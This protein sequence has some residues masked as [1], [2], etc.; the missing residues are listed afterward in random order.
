M[1][2]RSMNDYGKPLGVLLITL[3]AGV[4]AL[5]G[6]IT[7]SIGSDAWTIACWRGFVGGLLIAAYVLW[8]RNG[9]PV[10]DS[11]RLGWRGWLLAS[12]GAVAG[13]AFIGAFKLTYVANV[14][15]MYA[16]VPFV[17]A[18]LERA[19]LGQKVRGQTM[20]AAGVS[21]CGVAIMVGGGL[22][23]L[24][25]VGDAVAVFMTLVCALYMVL[26]RV[27]R[28]TPVVWAGA[29]SGFQLF[30]LGWF[31]TD[32]FAVAFGDAVLIVLFGANWAL[33][34][35]LWTEGTRLIPAAE[36]GL[37]GSAEVPLAVLFAWLILTELPPIASFIGGAVVLAAVLA[38]AGRDILTKPPST[39]R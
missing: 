34:L 16:T 17:A 18:G 22:G 3:S 27:Y 28:D 32:P 23:G 36:A 24:K 4:F 8:R 31:V 14:A 30:A 21:L 2:T 5:A 7:K 6:V 10:R 25:I 37:L 13:I 19:M 26:I 20:L 38:H 15:I 11:L 35:I 33:A 39:S 29:I 1:R 9:A 12:V